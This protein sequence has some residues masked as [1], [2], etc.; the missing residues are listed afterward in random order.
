MET[1]EAVVYFV[2]LF[3]KNIILGGIWEYNMKREEGFR[4]GLLTLLT[5]YVGLCISNLKSTKSL[6]MLSLYDMYALR[7]SSRCPYIISRSR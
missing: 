2:V 1:T 3:D 6:I 4:H 7:M 5:D